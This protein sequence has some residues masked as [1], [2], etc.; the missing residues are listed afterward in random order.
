M[1]LSGEKIES[2]YRSQVIVWNVGKDT[3]NK[4]DIT[5]DDPLRVEF[6]PKTRIFNVDLVGCSREIRHDAAV[7]EE[8]SI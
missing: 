8:P 6:D 5:K 2:L 1:K 7:R 4:N 3:I